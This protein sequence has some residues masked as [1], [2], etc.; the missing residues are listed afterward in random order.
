MYIKT[1]APQFDPF[2]GMEKPGPS[3]CQ[4]EKLRDALW[5]T[6]NPWLDW[7]RKGQ[8]H[9]CSWPFHSCGRRVEILVWKFSFLL[10]YCL[11]LLCP[12]L[13]ITIFKSAQ[14]VLVLHGCVHLAR[15]H[16]RRGCLRASLLGLCP[17]LERGFLFSVLTAHGLQPGTV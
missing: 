1:D 14:A 11:F 12:F 9:F 4:V 8:V 16:R 7:G 13:I 15:T 17:P 6:S 3:L 2:E 5:A 10:P